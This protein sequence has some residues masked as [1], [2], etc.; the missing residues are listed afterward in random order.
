LIFREFKLSDVT[1]TISSQEIRKNPQS[2][3]EFLERVEGLKKRV[4]R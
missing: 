3:R 4:D 1:S 2:L